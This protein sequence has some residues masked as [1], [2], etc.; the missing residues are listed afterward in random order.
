M[1]SRIVTTVSEHDE[2]TRDLINKDLVNLDTDD[3]GYN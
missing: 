3:D 1:H 2:C